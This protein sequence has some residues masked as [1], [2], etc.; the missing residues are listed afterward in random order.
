[1][2][3]APGVCELH[4]PSE[5]VG[6]ERFSKRILQQTGKWH[7]GA[8]AGVFVKVEA[9]VNVVRFTKNVSQLMPVDQVNERTIDTHD[10]KQDALP[11]VVGKIAKLTELV[12]ELFEA[13]TAE[14]IV[15]G[16]ATATAMSDESV[17]AVFIKI[18]LQSTESELQVAQLL[19]HSPACSAELCIR[20]LVLCVY[21]IRESRHA[22]ETVVMIDVG[23]KHWRIPGA[24]QNP[25]LI[26][27][28]KIIHRTC[29]IDQTEHKPMTGNHVVNNEVLNP[30][31]GVVS[32]L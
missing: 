14:R 15:D 8:K 27:R 23:P 9:H 32:R 22:D 21:R 13:H 18:T 11:L 12:H 6:S 30:M 25:V 16:F 31:T 3:S 17:A 26:L 19:H 28:E 24:P 5:E 4:Q 1:M 7:D 20:L 2:R 10:D 29:L